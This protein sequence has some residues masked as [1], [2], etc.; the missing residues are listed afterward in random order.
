[1]AV[2]TVSRQVAAHGDEVAAELAK[3]LNYKFVTRKD[4]EKRI[5]ELGF[6]ESKMPKYDE[7]KPGFFASLAKNRDEYFNY[8]Q[9][10]ILEAAQQKNV[11]IIGRGA[12][13]V[14]QGSSK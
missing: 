2:I 12:F 14:L 9:Y 4:I 11:I 1:M 7:R 6:P 3:L 8:A 5:V 13:A 10:A